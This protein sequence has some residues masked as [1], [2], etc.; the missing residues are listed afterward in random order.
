MNDTHSKRN[1]CF[2]T[3]FARR[4]SKRADSVAENFSD[5]EYDDSG[6]MN[7]DHYLAIINSEVNTLAASKNPKEKEIMLKNLIK[8]INETIALWEDFK[9]EYFEE[10]GGIVASASKE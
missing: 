10:Y 9:E 5:N 8:H 1:K 2:Y 6:I 3:K 7:I 4:I